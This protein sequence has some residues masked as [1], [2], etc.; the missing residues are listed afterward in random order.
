MAGNLLDADVDGAM[1]RSQRFAEWFV[2]DQGDS[3]SVTIWRQETKLQLLSLI[4]FRESE[5]V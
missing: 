4:K 3:P 2:V 5:R 1:L